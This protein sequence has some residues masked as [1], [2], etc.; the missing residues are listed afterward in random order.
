MRQPNILDEVY[1]FVGR[2]IYY[3]SEHAKVLHVAWI[4]HTHLV[5]SFNATPRLAILSPEK[6]SGKT[7]LL[8]VTKLL[9]QN[10]VSMV[11]P[12]PASLYSLIEAEAV[13][14]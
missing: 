1:D 9:V 11:S 8:E 13:D 3:P 10:P 14:R 12:S 2:Y 7:R 6:R 5:T 4:A